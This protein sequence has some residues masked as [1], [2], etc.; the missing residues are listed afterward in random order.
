VIGLKASRRQEVHV[1]AGVVPA[2]GLAE[3]TTA[4][5]WDAELDVVE[6][7]LDDDAITCVS[8]IYL[9]IWNFSVY[10]YLLPP[11]QYFWQE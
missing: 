8:I 1:G 9:K 4:G 10:S 7:G 11:R 2:P 5:D 6:A 3:F